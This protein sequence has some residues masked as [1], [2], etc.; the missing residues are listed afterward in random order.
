M[1]KILSLFYLLIILFARVPGQGYP[2]ND[3]KISTDNSPSTII[4]NSPKLFCDE[5]KRFLITWKDYRNGEENTYAQWFDSLG[6][7]IGNNFKITAST[8]IAF[9]NDGSFINNYEYGHFSGIDAFF[10]NLD[11]VIYGYPNQLINTITLFDKVD[12][13]FIGFDWFK[14]GYSISGYSNGFMFIESHNGNTNLEKYDST[15]EL[16]KSIPLGSSLSTSPCN[17]SVSFNMDDSYM[18]TYFNKKRHYY[19][20]EA[21]TL[22]F[23]IYATFFLEDDSVIA[24]DILIDEAENQ[25]DD[26]WFNPNNSPFIKSLS[27]SDS[28]YQVFWIYRNSSILNFAFYNSLG[29]KVGPTK[30]YNLLNATSSLVDNRTISNFSFSNI[31]NNKFAVFISTTEKDMNTIMYHNN[32]LFFDKNGLIIDSLYNTS[33][34]PSLGEQIF[35]NRRNGFYTISVL[36]DDIFLC[37]LNNLNI[38]NYFK[39]NEEEF[40]SND[41]K[42]SIFALDDKTNFITWSNETNCIGQKTDSQGNLI[43]STIELDGNQ[44]VFSIFGKCY[45]LWIRSLNNNSTQL[46][47]TIYNT[48]WN[49]V[50]ENILI[51]SDDSYFARSSITK[52]SDS[53]FILYFKNRTTNFIRALDVNFNMIKEIFWENTDPIETFRIEKN[54]EYSFWIHTTYYSLK[55][56]QDLQLISERY[57]FNS[58]LFLGNDVF[59]KSQNYHNYTDTPFFLPDILVGTTFTTANDTLGKSFYMAS[60]VEDY[61]LSL[62]PNNDFLVLWKS[63]NHLYARAFSKEGIAKTDSFIIHSNIQSF[64]KQPTVLVNGNKVFFTWSDARN[65]GR[66]YDIYGSIFDLSKVVSVDNYEKVNLPNQFSLSQNYPNPFNPTTKIK[67]TIPV[68][69]GHAPSLRISLKVYDILGK[70]VATLVNEEKPA[71]NYEIEFDGS[72]LSSGVYFYQLS[73][74]GGVETKKLILMK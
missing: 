61:S 3:F 50:E 1:K 18:I 64:K 73:T 8:Q 35:Y 60:S 46:G 43:E 62:L 27:I 47:Y 16:K 39:I 68:E 17:F 69:T 34:F 65:E 54:D 52:L 53:L 44:C 4:Q 56:S 23:G 22:P 15:G 2:I 36:N 45:N 12:L 38:V 33:E 58:D 31:N 9:I 29:V 57:N 63:Q 59:L 26:S 72:N 41:T 48:N 13:T 19:N 25:N 71:G 66:G 7:K 14:T 49:K 21:D 40:G 11:G 32:L 24:K 30:S 28:L 42:P 67:F 6:N 55:Y 10:V 20:P 5:S 37:E 51:T 70:E 74:Y